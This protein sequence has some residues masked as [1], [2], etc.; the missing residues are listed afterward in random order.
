M[1][2]C[3]AHREVVEGCAMCAATPA[4][5]LGITEEEWNRKKA[6]VEAAGLA[7]CHYCGFEQYR[8]HNTCVLCG[9]PDWDYLS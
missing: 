1:S 3:S 6:K 4:M 9:V 8:N 5:V 2:V 7:Q